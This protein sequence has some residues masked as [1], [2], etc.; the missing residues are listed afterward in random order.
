MSVYENEDFYQTTG[1]AQKLRLNSLQSPDEIRKVI[2][3]GIKQIL[4]SNSLIRKRAIDWYFE[5]IP[6]KIKT[7]KASQLIS[8]VWNGMRLLPYDNDDISEACGNTMY[9][10]MQ[11]SEEIPDRNEQLEIFSN[12]YGGSMRVGFANEDKTGSYGYASFQS[13]SNA[14]EIDILNLVKDEFKEIASNTRDMFKIIYNPKIMFEFNKFKSF[15][16][17]EVIPSQVAWDQRLI[18]FNPSKLTTFG[19]P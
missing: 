7:E 11:S 12:L 5:E 15:F 19:I 17:K 16:A 2:S 14:L 3:Y 9:L 10:Y 6:D 4:R 8:I 13:I 1:I 18:V